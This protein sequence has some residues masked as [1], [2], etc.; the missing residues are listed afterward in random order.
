MEIPSR[1]HSP[2]IER[3]EA[4]GDGAGI[5]AAILL[6]GLRENAARMRYCSRCVASHLVATP[7]TLY[8]VTLAPYG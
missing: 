7:S 8:D 2:N 5:N 1:P 6:V 3:G 4:R